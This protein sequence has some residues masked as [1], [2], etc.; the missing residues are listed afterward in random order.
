MILGAGSAGC[1]LANRLSED[2]RISVAVIEAGPSSDT[3]KVDMP[4]ALL[5]TMHDPKYNWKYYS[6]PEPFLN[7]RKIFCPRG[8]M[9]GGSSSHNGMVHVR[10]HAQDFNRW[11][12]K[13]LTNWSYNHVLPYFKKLETWSGGDNK[14]RGGDGP[15]Q[16]SKSKINEKFPLYQAVIDAAKEAGYRYTEDSNGFMQEGFCTYDV[17]IKDGMRCNIGKAYLKEASKR[18]NV[19]I[20]MQSHVQK[21]IVEDSA[22]ADWS[23]VD[24]ALLSA[25]KT[26]S[27]EISPVIAASGATVV[28]NSSGWRMDPEVPLVVSE[29]NPEALDEIPKGIVANPNCTTMVAMPVLSPLHKCA[30]LLSLRISTYQAVSGA[31]LAGVEELEGQINSATGKAT[32]LAYDGKA[33]EFPEPSSFPQ[34]IAF[35]VLPHAGSFIDDGRGET[36]EEQKLRNESRKIL[37]IPNLLVSPVCVRVPVFTGHSLAINAEFE[38]SIS[39]EEATEILSKT[40]GVTL[41]DVPTPIDCTGIDDTL[42]GRIRKD[43]TVENGLALFL[44]GDNLRKGAALNAIQIAEELLKR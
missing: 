30:E 10:G 38:N 27:L 11:A 13:G 36:D 23:N 5:Y 24:I 43:E 1:V 39:P 18:K 8:K 12:Q 41:C 2:P 40:S 4:S 16:V 22:K 31:G 26:A 19:D 28:D 42:V 14:Y 44:S 9:I 35:N 37:N 21:I 20:F 6:E 33:H 3:W 25:G 34:S 29:V 17:T 7:N 15:L 32:Q